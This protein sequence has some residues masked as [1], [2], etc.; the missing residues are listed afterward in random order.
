MGAQ[1]VA[2]SSSENKRSDAKELGS[3]EY[4]V[5]SRPEEVELHMGTFTHILATHIGDDF[6]CKSTFYSTVINPQD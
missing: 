4:V 2:L 1:V 5:T 6:D 3:D